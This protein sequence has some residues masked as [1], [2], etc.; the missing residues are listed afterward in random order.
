MRSRKSRDS[1]AGMTSPQPIKDRLSGISILDSAQ[2]KSALDP[3][4]LADAGADGLA[5]L[6]KF[7]PGVGFELLEAGGDGRNG[8]GVG[9]DALLDLVPEQ[10]GRYRCAGAG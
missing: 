8:E 6:R 9:L 7:G 3:D 5:Q 1:G 2:P 10:W 4:L